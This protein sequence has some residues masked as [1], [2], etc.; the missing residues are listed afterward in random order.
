MRRGIGGAAL[1]AALM[2]TVLGAARAQVSFRGNSDLCVANVAASPPSPTGMP[3]G[4]EISTCKDRQENIHYFLRAP[5]PNR[6]GVCRVYE[7]EIFPGG[8]ADRAFIRT[9]YGA[10]IHVLEGWTQRP[11]EAWRGD[12]YTP[13]RESFAL[14]TDGACPTMSD[15]RYLRTTNVSDGMLKGFYQAW[16][17]A[18]SSPQAFDKVFAGL[19]AK[20]GFSPAFLGNI[21]DGAL[22]RQVKPEDIRCDD[23]GCAAWVGLAFIH[24]DLV[25]GRFAFTGLHSAPVP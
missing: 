17:A 14:V 23:D 12:G 24:F 2:L 3:P 7:E 8:P 25:D 1:V 5:R 21:R 4:T 15:A 6:D 13:V 9:D 10:D 16:G 20:A 22:R 18:T 11:P 19:V